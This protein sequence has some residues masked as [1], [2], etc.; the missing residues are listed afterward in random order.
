MSIRGFL[1][2]GLLKR[3][4]LKTNRAGEDNRRS[5]EKRA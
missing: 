1:K 3:G 2:R 4:L 5:A